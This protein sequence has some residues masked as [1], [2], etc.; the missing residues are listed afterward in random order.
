MAGKQRTEAEL[1]EI[2]NEVVRLRKENISIVNISRS[3]HVGKK[4]V[5]KILEENGLPRLRKLK[6]DRSVEE[7]YRRLSKLTRKFKVLMV[8][9]IALELS[10]ADFQ[11]ESFKP[12]NF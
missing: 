4:L 2:K 8:F 1:E 11:V 5:S 10:R 9:D 7:N 3:V 6:K 12:W